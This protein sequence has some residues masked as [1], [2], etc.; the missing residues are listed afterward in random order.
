M[1][2]AILERIFIA[3]SLIITHSFEMSTICAI[4]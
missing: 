1:F 4:E 2:V 3:V